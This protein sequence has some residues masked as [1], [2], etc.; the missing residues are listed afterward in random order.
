MY[1][2]FITKNDLIHIVK[3]VAFKLE[4]TLFFDGKKIFLI[5]FEFGVIMYNV[6]FYAY[7]RCSVFKKQVAAL[8]GRMEIVM[9]KNS[10]LIKLL[11]VIFAVV[12]VMSS[13]V[14]AIAEEAV[15]SSDYE[16]SRPGSDHNKIL[17]SADI[18][19][20]IIGESIGEEE[21]NYLISY[22]DLEIGYDDG[23][24]TKKVSAILEG[25]KLGIIAYPYTY[26]AASEALISWIPVSVTLG[27]D[28]RVLVKDGDTY[29]ADFEGYDVESGINSVDVLYTLT[30]KV[31]RA[32]AEKLLNKAKNDIPAL[33]REIAEKTEKYN[34]DLTKFNTYE[35]YRIN[36]E[37]YNKYLADLRIYNERLDA[38]NEYLEDK[39]LYEIALTLRQQYEKDLEKYKADYAVYTE[40]LAQ[41]NEY[42]KSLSEYNDYLKTVKAYRD[43]V[44]IIDFAAKAM[45]PLK[46][47]ALAA[48]N[49]NT[50]T[51][52]LEERETLE[53]NAVG[54]PPLVIT[55]AGEA[56]E[57]LRT[58]L[59]GYFNYTT[60]QGRYGY[61]LQNYDGFKK[62]FVDLFI[63]LDYL[64]KNPS[65]RAALYETDRDEK[66][67]ILVAQL[68]LI[69]HALSD[70]PV[71]SVKEEL[72]VGSKDADKYK[73]FTYT[74]DFTMDSKEYTISEILYGEKILEDKKAG[75]PFVDPFPAEVTAP[76]A[77][78]TPVAKPT[79]P[80]YVAPPAEPVAAPDPGTAPEAVEDPGTAPEAAECPEEYI[81]PVEYTE[82][83]A[84]KDDI[85]DRTLGFEGDYYLS[86]ERTVSKKFVDMDEVNVK[87]YSENGAELLYETTVDSGTSADYDGVIP[88]KAE[89]D[90]AFYTFAGWQNHLNE[91]V[92]LSEVTSDLMLYPYFEET[93]KKYTV[94]F[95][96]DGT[97]QSLMLPYGTIP[98]FDG[99][100][101]YEKYR[102]NEVF[103][104]IGWDKPLTEVTGDITYT[105]VFSMEF[106]A[107]S[108][109][110]KGAT[111]S[112]EDGRLT[113]N[114]TDIA[115]SDT[116]L[117]I[118]NLLERAKDIGSLRMITPAL[119][120]DF[121]YTQILELASAG[122]ERLH[123]SVVEYNGTN[124]KV[125]V[126]DYRVEA[127]DSEGK[128]VDA[129][130][131]VKLTDNT[132]PLALNE[133][134]K[135]FYL[136][137]EGVRRYTKFALENEELS[138][139]AL[140]GITYTLAYEYTVTA[141]AGNNVALSV[142]RGLYSFGESAELILE[143]PDGM[144]LTK[145]YYTDSE[146]IVTEFNSTTFRMPA[147][148]ITVICE[149]EYIRYK[150]SFVS[151]NSV[152]SSVRVKK[153]EMPTAPEDPIKLP[154]DTYRYEFKG[155]SEEISPA[156]GEK[157]YHAVFEEIPLEESEETEKGPSFYK[158]AV[159][160]SFIVGG[161]LLLFIAIGVAVGLGRGF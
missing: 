90:R 54:A 18:L 157:V 82:L 27:D 93:V 99:E 50:V 5:L 101:S 40:Y 139:A 143:L 87:F 132:A 114:Y 49:G 76:A 66:Y 57:N 161:A 35:Q 117:D 20:K 1:R 28:I 112:I 67:R 138:F 68:Y 126:Y 45:T 111:V 81:P 78:P 52:V 42:D 51:S 115:A 94:T 23:I 36:L 41:K 140:S 47:S 19:E 46:R 11:A 79:E 44:E 147:S 8:S 61:Y 152:I 38:Y 6:N 13:G 59:A 130:I 22:G 39:A 80:A 113:V 154:D 131:S 148:D 95:D 43:R 77:A 85:P 150:I 24:T 125:D 34:K 110:G 73:Q 122:A 48:I 134:L 123:I 55:L 145:L 2:S 7:C 63:S 91:R 4:A 58:L 84:A 144:K 69:A 65:V 16:L 137:S 159:L 100:P 142:K 14:L 56:T 160:I 12:T 119:T 149:V 26:T 106:L 127:F 92:S 151:E 62:N 96:V 107:P 109:Q 108:N 135:L 33:A 32:D 21:R 153:G 103:S 121:G 155:W 71:K 146:G 31:N 60:E 156:D 53:S 70:E 64:Y 97:I 29:T 133:R 102:G 25:N 120:V 104:F 124:H 9:K 10:L 37:K 136:D 158:K 128:P 72:V 116:V 74:K 129:Q 141:S 118:T 30:V 89:D 15:I 86:L 98:A 17:S 75:T 88:A 105:A 83:I 3:G